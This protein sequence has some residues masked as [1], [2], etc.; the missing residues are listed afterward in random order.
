MSILTASS[1]FLLLHGQ[2]HERRRPYYHYLGQIICNS[3]IDA[4]RL[5]F[6]Y[7]REVSIS[8]MQKNKFLAGIAD[9]E[10]VFDVTKQSND[11]CT[12]GKE[13]E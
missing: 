13:R 11:V 9:L 1:L 3:H 4:K 8:L 7:S 10:T 6:N 2:C 12:R 5:W